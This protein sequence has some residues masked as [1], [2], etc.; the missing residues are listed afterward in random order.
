MSVQRAM[1][2]PGRGRA[3]DVWV[4]DDRGR[5]QRVTVYCSEAGRHVRVFL[6]NYELTADEGRVS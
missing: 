2:V 3:L 6:D 5:R 1:A 4:T